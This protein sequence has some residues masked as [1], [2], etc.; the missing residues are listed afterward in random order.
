MS[1][2]PYS[3]MAVPTWARWQRNTHF[4]GTDCC[5]VVSASRERHSGS[6]WTR[7]LL[8]CQ[9]EGWRFPVCSG[10]V[11]RS[12]QQRAGRETQDGVR[13]DRAGAWMGNLRWWWGWGEWGLGVG[14]GWVRLPRRDYHNCLPLPP[15]RTQRFY[16]GA[17]ASAGCGCGK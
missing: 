16:F 12:C 17:T 4:P 5:K 8:E 7:M 6:M 14:K 10:A 2:W 9:R 3:F 11:G 15:G 1:L 13:E